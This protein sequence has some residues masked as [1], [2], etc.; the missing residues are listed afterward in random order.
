MQHPPAASPNVKPRRA[1]PKAALLGIK[2][3]ELAYSPPG[4]RQP[5]EAAL[6]S[7]PTMGGGGPRGLGSQP[8]A[9]GARVR[10]E[11]LGG[12][13][14]RHTSLGLCPAMGPRV[15]DP[16]RGETQPSGAGA[17]LPPSTRNCCKTVPRPSRPA[18]K[19]GNAPPPRPLKRD[20]LLGRGGKAG[21]RRRGQ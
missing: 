1:A 6:V 17:A 12:G 9:C 5:A 11:H 4:P 16:R 15:S 20:T 14:T 21:R 7:I 19:R 2:V 18:A 13:G 10:R 3:V 8:E